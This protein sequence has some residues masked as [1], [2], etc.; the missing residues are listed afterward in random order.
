LNLD[1]H[2]GAAF[3][4]GYGEATGAMW[5]T[6]RLQLTV[7]GLDKTMQIRSACET[8]MTLERWLSKTDV[9]PNK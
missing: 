5:Q 2:N 1:A 3:F 8:F 7:A 9:M 4:T 6:F